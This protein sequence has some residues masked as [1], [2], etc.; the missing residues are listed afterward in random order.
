MAHWQTLFVAGAAARLG[1]FVAER[2]DEIEEKLRELIDEGRRLPSDGYY[3]AWIAKN[4]WWQEVRPTW[5]RYDL[6]VSPVT[7]CPPFALGH[8]TPGQVAG[9]PISFYGWM[10]F[11]VP[12]NMTGQP[13]ISVPAGMTG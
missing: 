9:R 4:D 13:A 8:D 7:A 1:P 6:V 12:F 3:R 10:S 5:E 2:G 11:T